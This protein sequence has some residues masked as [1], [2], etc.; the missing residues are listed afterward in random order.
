MSIFRVLLTL[1][2]C[3]RQQW[4]DFSKV[5]MET[6]YS[7]AFAEFIHLISNVRMIFIVKRYSFY[8]HSYVFVLYGL[9]LATSALGV[10]RYGNPVYGPRIKQTYALKKI[11]H[12]R[13]DLLYC[14]RWDRHRLNLPCHSLDLA[15]SDFHL[16]GPLQK[17]LVF[18]QELQNAVWTWIHTF[19]PHFL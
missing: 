18:R 11:T 19:F 1:S 17:L 12:A 8:K 9:S 10:F 5:T 4:I 16:F 7:R 3:S 13:C 15:P 2:S 6:Y 14:L